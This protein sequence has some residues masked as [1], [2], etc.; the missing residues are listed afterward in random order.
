[1]PFAVFP[2]FCLLTHFFSIPSFAEDVGWEPASPSPPA[3]SPCS[4]WVQGD[5][6]E[7]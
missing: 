5:G 3:S 4:G 6:E 1:M 2:F 7:E